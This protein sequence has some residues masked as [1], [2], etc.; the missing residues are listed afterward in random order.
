MKVNA[1]DPGY[2]ATDFNN[3]AG[4]R[5]VEQAATVLVHLAT[6]DEDGPNG[7]FF[8]EDGARPW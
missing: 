8:N 6:L 2:T 7:G 4:P 5:S 1:G 3:H